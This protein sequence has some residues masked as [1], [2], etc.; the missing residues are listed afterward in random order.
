MG[1]L[2]SETKVLSLSLS[3][4]VCK[5][6][7]AVRIIAPFMPGRCNVKMFYSG[8]SKRERERERERKRVF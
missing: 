3:M 5:E 8:E 4:Y 7:R 2:E 6:R 1:P